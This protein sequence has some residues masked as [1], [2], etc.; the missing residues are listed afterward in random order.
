M[1]ETPSTTSQFFAPRRDWFVMFV[2]LLFILLFVAMVPLSFWMDAP[3]WQQVLMSGVGVIIAISTID[4]LFFTVYELGP[5]GLDVHSQLRKLH[6]P[7]RLMQG[8]DKGGFM[9]L[10][11]TKKRKRFAF[12]RKSLRIQVRDMMWSEITISPY[13]RD[14]FLEQ[15]LA[16][17]DVERSRRAT[18]S[19]VSKKR[20]D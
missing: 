4:K 5:N 7:Y 14:A 9:G 2:G 16:T 10:F 20:K 18:A 6:V 1:P 13:E 8:I 15:L 11:T 19:R 3:L 17:I 12:S